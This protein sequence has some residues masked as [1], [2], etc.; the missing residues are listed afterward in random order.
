MTPDA[1][2]TVSGLPRALAMSPTTTPKG[3]AAELQ[4]WID[5]NFNVIGSF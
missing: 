4:F 1:S 5:A 3:C 2:K